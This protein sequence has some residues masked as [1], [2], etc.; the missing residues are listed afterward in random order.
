MFSTC[1]NTLDPIREGKYIY[2]PDCSSATKICESCYWKLLRNK[3]IEKVS[4][5]LF[6]CYPTDRAEVCTHSGKTK[7]LFDPNLRRT[8][9]VCQECF[10]AF[11]ECGWIIPVDGIATGKWA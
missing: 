11:T 10:S 8:I 9:K 3:Q 6:F 2:V 5:V 4:G 1:D 7:K